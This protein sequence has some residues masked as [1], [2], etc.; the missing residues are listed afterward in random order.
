MSDVSTRLASVA[1]ADTIAALHAASWRSAYRG[2][3]SEDT[4][5]RALDG[6]RRTHWRSKLATM[7]PHD[8]VLIAS[9]TGF[10]AVW[11]D[12]D[13]GFGAYIDNLHVHPERRSAGLGRRLLREAMRRVAGRGETG[14]YLWVFDGNVRAI[15]FYRRLGGEIVEG[16]F[17]EIDG[18]EVAQSRIVWRDIARLADACDATP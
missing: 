17:D 12:G 7:A 1:D 14:A 4:L 3:L 2:I 8:M 5:G 13:P 18:V 10:I 16:G 15:D 6:E 11:G 9:D